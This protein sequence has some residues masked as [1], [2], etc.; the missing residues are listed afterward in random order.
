MKKPVL[1]LLALAP[2]TG[3]SADDA[4]SISRDYRNINNEAIDA[5]MMTTS[6]ARAK[7]ANEKVL[8]TYSA[9]IS[10]VDKRLDLWVQ[11]AEE[12]FIIANTLNSESAATLIAENKINLKRLELERARLQRLAANAG[13]DS[14]NLQELARGGGLATVKANLEKGTRFA[15]MMGKF[16]E[17]W[18]KHLPPNFGDLEKLFADRVARL[19][20]MQ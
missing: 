8:K 5:L 4:N 11:N 16:R 14:P 1:L 2:L 10:D 12:K 17:Q 19:E 3:C 7:I 13:A 18:K 6:E 15:E 20:R 9:R